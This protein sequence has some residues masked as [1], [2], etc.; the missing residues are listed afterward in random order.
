MNTGEEIVEKQPNSRRLS[1]KRL[2]RSLSFRQARVA[3]L[4]AFSLGV[5]FS[6]FQIDA[7]LRAERKRTDITFQR[8]LRVADSSAVQ[9]AFGLDNMLAQRVVDG[10]MEYRAVFHAEIIDN[11]DDSMAKRRRPEKQG[12]MK[13]LARFLFGPAK[14]FSLPLHVRENQYHVGTLIITIDTFIIAEDFLQR[15]GLILLSGVVRNLALACILGFLFHSMLTRPLKQVARNIKTHHDAVEIPKTHAGDELGELVQAYNE[16]YQ[17]RTAAQ[18]R[19]RRLNRGLENRVAERTEEIE[20]AKLDLER[21]VEERTAEMRK[22]IVLAENASRAKSEFLAHM[23]HELRTPLNAI[24]GF[25][26]I[27]ENETFGEIGHPKYKEYAGDINV[28]SQHLL[29]L[30]TD[31]LDVS[32]VEAGE[33]ELDEGTVD[34]RDL[35]DSCQTLVRDTVARK[36]LKL[37]AEFDPDP[38]QISADV[39]LL[40][41]AVLN[42]LSNAVKFTDDGGA[43]NIRAAKTAA[44]AVEISI[45]DNGCGIH[46]DHIDKVLEPFG[47]AVSRP[48]ISNEGTG[49]GLPLAK[50]FTEL[51]G[52]TL[53]LESELGKGT[54]VTITLPPERTLA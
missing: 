50:R 53:S 49:L 27:W 54:K 14:R 33:M 21:R 19:L 28:A 2:S 41:Q 3:V 4:V 11:H 17:L 5:L 42:L 32:K 24:M 36:G 10:L 26:Q 51:H 52:G 18:E 30:I 35:I 29:A 43:V 34:V 16:Q 37:T 25:S 12:R 38:G 23:S 7:D 48:D 15:S 6:A 13:P 1:L 46:K 45:S 20:L 22:A 44:G 8:I 9:A 39:R 47:Q 31:I 40:R